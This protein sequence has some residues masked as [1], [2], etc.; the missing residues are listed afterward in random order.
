M[1]G[2]S[3][4]ILRIPVVDTPLIGKGMCVGFPEDGYHGKK[5]LHPEVTVNQGEGNKWQ[6]WTIGAKLQAGTTY[7]KLGSGSEPTTNWKIPGAK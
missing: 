1:E 3:T 5:R 6:N 2:H 7:R 4:G